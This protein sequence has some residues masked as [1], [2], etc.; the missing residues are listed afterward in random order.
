MIAISDFL[1]ELR[2]AG[3]QLWLQDGRLR[4][5]PVGAL[6]G[7]RLAVLRE[8]RDEV[9]ATMLADPA[10]PARPDII[11]LSDHQQ[12]MW[13]LEQ[14]GVLG[15]AYNQTALH[16]IT[17]DLDVAALRS[18]IAGIMQRHEILRTAFPARDGI[19]VQVVEPPGDPRFTLLD[20]SDLSAA[21][22][23]RWLDERKRMYAGY[24]FDISV[25]Q[26]FQTELIRL[27]PTEHVL[28][29]RSYHLVLDGPSH[30]NLYQ[31]LRTLYRAHRTGTPAEV[32]ELSMQ[33]ADYALWQN[34]RDG[35]ET[36]LHMDYWTQR[37][38]GAPHTFDLPTDRPRAATAELDGDTVEVPVSADV[39]E[40]LRRLARQEGAT[41]FMVLLAAFHT[42]LYRWSGQTDVSVGTILD[43]RARPDVEANIGHFVNPVVL[44]ADLAGRP[45]FAG[46]LRQLQPRLLEAYEHRHA[47]FDRLVAELRPQRDLAVQPLFQVL[48]TYLRDEPFEML[49]GLTVTPI[50][51]DE[52][53]AMF[54][55]TL[56]A[57]EN[58]TGEL[59]VGLEY[60]T[61]LF[62][63]ATMQRLAGYLVT[64]LA[65]IV[66]TPD[67]PI[68]DLHLMSAAQRHE[69]LE[70]WNG[71][72]TRY[73]DDICLHQ[74]IE[75]QV[76]ATPTAVAAVFDGKEL[77]YRELDEQANALAR[78]LRE[79][80]VGPDERAGIALPRS[81]D[82]V[83]ANL[84]VLKSGGAC[85]P[86]DPTYPAARQQ[87]IAQDAA[88]R[89]LIRPAGGAAG[90]EGGT[91][92][93]E[94]SPSASATG[95]ANLA[96]PANIAWV[97]YTSGSTGRPKG[98][99][100]PH[101]A[102][103]N[104]VRWQ[105][106]Q[107]PG[108][109][110]RTLQWAALSFDIFYQEMLTTLAVG[111]TLFL[112][113]EDVR[114]DFERLLDVIEAQRI[115]RIFM[116][117]VALQ[118]M[119][120]RAARLNRFPPSLRAVLTAGEQLQAT[121]AIREFFT[122]LPDCTLFNQYGPIEVHL[123][124]SHQLGGDPAQ[125]SALPPIGRPFDNA[126]TYVL[127]SELRPV[128]PG[129][130]G[131]LFVAGT[132]LARGYLGR[133]ELTAERFLP[134]PFGDG[135]RMYRT[136]DQVR[137]NAYGQLEFIGRLDD[138]VKIR[139]FRV[140]VA[141]IE[142][143]LTG[144]PQVV[145]CAVA[146]H[147]YGVGDRRLV[148]YVV[149][150][151]QAPPTAAELR[152]FLA[153]RLPDY[154]VPAAYLTVTELPH[155]PSGKL[156]RAL[157]PRPDDEAEWAGAAEYEPPATPLQERIAAIW[158]EVL[159]VPRVG[160]RDNFFELGGHSL[161]AVAVVNKVGDVIG[162]TVALRTLFEAPTV[163]DLAT[164]L[165]EADPS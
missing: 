153:D 90:P 159:A 149:L 23:Q 95:P 110:G 150:D 113:E 101:R 135:A 154:M 48:F 55:L 66:T 144:H 129:V 47:P 139:G 46:L 142:S 79:L 165:S 22:Q 37:L 54:D 112:V 98:V 161:L 68:D 130:A 78:Q 127:D 15:A 27:S 164:R 13:F 25:A 75:R 107:G 29:F 103:L 6:D 89:L 35:A 36:K 50:E 65:G 57:H 108:G 77:T 2:V 1:E 42:L 40:G 152:A 86:I 34:S 80:G 73:D 70:L 53:K 118:G 19:G 155:T 117:F 60:Q 38:A 109:R 33:Y 124:T 49:D 14:L 64:L 63:R 5:R 3:V 137:W 83:V 72:V 93:L 163:A 123:A 121:P 162:R 81:L 120:E 106:R 87:L 111:E 131:E 126:R 76:A 105:Q 125:W 145:E 128:P 74:V 10:P 116:P 148:A 85:V 97:L 119:A 84:A 96:D 160:V 45:T 143:V 67:V 114:H 69:V 58:E 134:D 92:V 136:G 16:R 91:P 88:L 44:R 30:A 21:E 39:A 11:P 12:G 115:E 82:M 133:P 52:R 62:E 156:S 99:A 59:T 24:R 8:R 56:F 122:R 157:L 43:G 17:G 20:V 51:P 138:Q 28:V 4:Y 158:A 9:I 100:M 7:E 18:A 71:T 141:E 31:E 147:R 146:A 151:P 102:L 26:N 94:F 32:P 132:P 61:A 140:E 104:Q 41:L